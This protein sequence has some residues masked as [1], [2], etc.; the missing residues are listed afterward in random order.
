MGGRRMRWKARP[1]RSPQSVCSRASPRRVAQFRF[2]RASIDGSPFNIARGGIRQRCGQTCHGIRTCWDSGKWQR[3]HGPRPRPLHRLDRGA[4]L[5]RF[6]G[7]AAAA[8]AAS[9]RDRELAR[10]AQRCEAVLRRTSR[11]ANTLEHRARAQFIAR[12]SGACSG[13]CPDG[14]QLASRPR[15]RPGVEH[16]P[17]VHSNR[18]PPWR[19]TAT[20]A[21]LVRSTDRSALLRLGHCIH[22]PDDAR[23][24]VADEDRPILALDDVDR[25]SHDVAARLKAPEEGLL[26]PAGL[27]EHHKS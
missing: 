14:N 7:A 20:R 8:R 10:R 22:P 27:S 6:A 9:R 25:P 3:L 11:P 18:S 16:Q 24:V 13:E 1:A 2:W 15:T 5:L 19:V 26:S 17:A 12:G 23:M 4:R 21:Q